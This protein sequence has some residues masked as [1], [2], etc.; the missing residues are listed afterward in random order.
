MKTINI[1]GCCVSRDLFGLFKNNGGFDIK[2]CITNIS[3]LSVCS[4]KLSENVKCTES[5]LPNSNHYA[6]RCNCLDLNKTVFEYL[7][8]F[9][10]DYTLIDLGILF[11]IYTLK[12]KMP[13]DTVTYI[14]YKDGLKQ[15]PEFLENAPFEIIE[16]FRFPDKKELFFDYLQQYAEL[17]KEHIPE[18][19]MIILELP[20][21]QR[22]IDK[23]AKIDYFS[24]ECTTEE[25]PKNSARCFDTSL[26]CRY[27][28][29]AYKLFEKYFPNAHV[30]KCPDTEVL[31]N[32]NH[33]WGLHPL[34]YTIEFYQYAL[35]AVRAIAFIGDTQNEKIMLKSLQN[36][37][38]EILRAKYFSVANSY[39]LQNLSVISSNYV[40][41]GKKFTICFNGE[42]GTGCYT[43]TALV[44]R[45][46]ETVWKKLGEFKKGSV[47]YRPVFCGAYEACVKIKD[48]NNVEIKKFFSFVVK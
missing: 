18:E 1:L 35:D 32:Q 20:L 5:D 41:F 21:T 10:A 22:F 14:T 15:N 26:T 29:R 2:Q 43:Y 13:D 23:N 39:N 11:F 34:H 31:C 24:T 27:L 40:D 8:L 38:T 45:K 9:N 6:Q 44:K 17:I 47:Q 4:P 42:G 48:T 36:A 30:I 16:K 37:Y 7:S 3:P 19:K 25:I 12:V 46:N 28:K 33:K